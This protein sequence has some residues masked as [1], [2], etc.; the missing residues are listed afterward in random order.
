MQV[1]ERM[2][3][4]VV[5]VSSDTTHRKALELMQQKR[6]RRLPVVD[7]DGHCV[8]IVSQADLARVADD[9]EVAEVV[10][11]VSAKPESGGLHGVVA[12]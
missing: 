11:E 7:D 6:L 12:I 1:R 9:H 8:G 10:R 4:P 5:T 2:S 3:S